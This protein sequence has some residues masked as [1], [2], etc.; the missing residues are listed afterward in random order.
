ML[1]VQLMLSIFFIFVFSTRFVV[2]FTTTTCTH[3]QH[4]SRTHLR[5]LLDDNNDNNDGSDTDDDYVLM[6][7]L[8]NRIKNLQD[9]ETKLPLVILDSMLPRQT[10]K[11]EIKNKLLQGLIQHR[12]RV[13]ENPTLG[14]LGKAMLQNGDVI[15]LNKGVEVEIQVQGENLVEFKAKRRFRLDGEVDNTSQGWTEGNIT[16]LCS[17]EEDKKES[18]ENNVSIST[19]M[20]K[21]ITKAKE[22]K[23]PNFNLPNDV[24]LIERWIELAKQNERQSGQ[25]D[26][27][28]EELGEIPKENEPSDLAFWIG[29]MI[30]P[31]PAMGVASEIRP[32]LL[33]SESAEERI[34]IAYD[35][36]FRSIKHMD[37]SARMW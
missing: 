26:S 35:G 21:A 20:S 8:Q 37:G 28:L 9:K 33:M 24:N 14:M 27:L 6:S 25:I 36:L 34:N 7:S 11:L 17:K 4:R 16:F 1:K 29:S 5:G 31:L 30:N 32:A 10:L 22:I 13:C 23:A 12:L 19:S 15:C 3:Q 18:L 2:A